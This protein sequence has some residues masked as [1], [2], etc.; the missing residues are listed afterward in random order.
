MIE[1]KKCGMFLE[2]DD[3]FCSGCGHDQRTD[4]EPAVIDPLGVSIDPKRSVDNLPEKNSASGS[5]H[6]QSERFNSSNSECEDLKLFSNDWTLLLE[7]KQTVFDF[8]VEPQ[9]DGL[10]QFAV[11]VESGCGFHATAAKRKLEKGRP[12]TLNAG[13]LV[14]STD[15]AGLNVFDLSVSYQKEGRPF[16]YCAS[17]T[18][19]IHS[20]QVDSVKNIHI[21]VK[22]HANDL[23]LNDP[24]DELLH[25]GTIQQGHATDR[26]IKTIQKMVESGKWNSLQS[27]LSKL[28]PIWK[29]ISLE[30]DEIDHALCDA[31][32][33][34]SALPPPPAAARRNRITLES[35][36]RKIHL[37][38][39]DTIQLGRQRSNAAGQDVCD[40][41]TRL[42]DATGT[43]PREENLYISK[44]HCYI[45]K[46]GTT[47]KIHDG[48]Q[49]SGELKYKT[50]VNGVFLDQSMLLPAGAATVCFG[51]PHDTEKR[52]SI[53]TRLILQKRIDGTS[54]PAGILLNRTDGIPECWL[55]VYG[56]LPLKHLGA[57]WAGW[58]L[59]RHQGGFCF[60]RGDAPQWLKTGEQI[61][62]ESRAVVVNE[63][64][65]WGL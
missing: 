16:S 18:Q 29:D 55:I 30:E 65:P 47:V 2:E 51:N 8:R 46:T 54:E 34:L 24:G 50:W 40:I 1:C 63:F 17:F 23:N 52:L 36:G 42:F 25:I 9:M 5:V 10:S 28:P 11:T 49:G 15:A 27:E 33:D 6:L 64:A 53:T 48:V 20:T 3:P 22:G 39:G 61:F 14:P 43:M 12:F 7:G 21:E 57:E 32:R 56:D 41:V 37:L 59:T 60:G 38:S 26:Q 45:V 13:G 19:H 62:A 4:I 35:D 44:E 58:C 31:F